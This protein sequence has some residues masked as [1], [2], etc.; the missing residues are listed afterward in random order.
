MI[1]KPV[2]ASE[3]NAILKTDRGEEIL[4]AVLPFHDRPVRPGPSREG[5]EVRVKN[6]LA[7]IGCR[8]AS[9]VAISDSAFVKSLEGYPDGLGERLTHEFAM[10]FTREITKR[11]MTN[12]LWGAFHGVACNYDYDTSH[13]IHRSLIDPL[14]GLAWWKN[15][16]GVTAQTATFTRGYAIDYV[17]PVIQTLLTFHAGAIARK[18][19]EITAKTAPFLGFLR[20]GNIPHGLFSDDTFVIRVS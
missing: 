15:D 10:S 14:G 9:V 2:S 5:I 13:A 7:D 3:W 11:P 19:D 16:R 17:H 6:A 18:D 8:P 20:D 4:K 12:L 1:G